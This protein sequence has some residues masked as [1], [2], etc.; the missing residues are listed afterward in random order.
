[1]SPLEAFGILAADDQLCQEIIHYK[2][3]GLDESLL[4]LQL[5]ACATLSGSLDQCRTATEVAAAA[6]LGLSMVQDGK[7]EMHELNEMCD[8]LLAAIGQFARA[9]AEVAGAN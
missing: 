1:M 5:A 3:Q 7:R 8:G 2:G 4:P 9:T 6:R